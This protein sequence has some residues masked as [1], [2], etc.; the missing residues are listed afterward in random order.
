VTPVLSHEINSSHVIKS[1]EVQSFSNFGSI[2][3]VNPGTAPH[4][5]L[6]STPSHVK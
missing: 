2:L 1:L 3:Q 6:I 4:Q 5:R